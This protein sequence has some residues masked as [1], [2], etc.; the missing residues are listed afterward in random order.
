MADLGR[1]SPPNPPEVKRFPF[2][3]SGLDSDI[4]G[5]AEELAY[6][7]QVGDQALTEPTI[8]SIDEA[9]EQEPTGPIFSYGM[10]DKQVV[11]WVDECYQESR[12]S[13]RWRLDKNRA[14]REAFLGQQDWSSKIPGQSKEFLPKTGVAATQFSAF[15]KR[16]LVQMGDWYELVMSAGA[17][18]D[19]RQA[20]ELLN[21]FLDDTLAE[22]NKVEDFATILSDAILLATTESLIIL[23]IHGNLRQ[24]DSGPEGQQ[25]KPK[26]QLRMDLV[27]FEC[28]FP[29]PTGKGL[30]EIHEIERDLWEVQDRAKEGLYD[31]KEVAKIKESTRL[32][33]GDQRKAAGINQSESTP[34]S[35]R[36]KVII[37]EFWGTLLNDKGEAAGRN[38]VCAV[39]NNK[40]LIRRPIPNP[41]WHGESPFVAEPII[42]VPKSTHHKALFD[43]AVQLN[44]AINELFNLFIDGAIGAVWGIN[45]L[46]HDYLVDP[47]QTDDGIPQGETLIVSSSLP[48]GEK[49]LE[50]LTTSRV[51]EDAMAVFEALNREFTSASLSSELK[52]GQFPGK[53]VK[54][55]EVIEQSQS[56]GV[57]LDSLIGQIEREVIR[58][59]LRKSFLVTMQ[60]IDHAPIEKVLGSIG[61]QGAWAIG[62]GNVEQ[63]QKM[64]MAFRD[65]STFRVKGL[66]ALMSRAR[67]FQKLMALMQV[68]TSNPIFLQAFFTK[69]SPDAILAF[70]MK[71]LQ[72]DPSD[73][74]RA[75]REEKSSFVE[76]MQMLPAFMQLITGGGGEGSGGAA[77]VGGPATGGA[78]IPAEINQTVNP[79]TGMSGQQ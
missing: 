16:G 70:A 4:S 44:L 79:M 31:E 15:L 72:L 1:P 51:P 57:M 23:K 68:V 38:I 65:R 21:A 39:A 49:V 14:N 64:F 59:I 28:Y 11:Q 76:E 33:D 32:N 17:P 61:V 24:P 10:T 67:D 66:S 60:F 78:Q 48:P 54:A 52:L 6:T 13:K 25:K 41:Y 35:S 9:I 22:D 8:T 20:K 73:F 5:Q 12:K 2:R 46:R 45:Q 50:P 19:S 75:T 27:P 3:Q 47:R 62:A 69:Y 55:T 26:W 56:Q 74:A 37:R 18:L 34:P 58:N 29:D 77:N 30:Y 63:R 71:T 36:K 53:E 40:H 7:A 43:E 42:R